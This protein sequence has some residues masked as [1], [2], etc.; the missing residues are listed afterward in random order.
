MS[1]T[2]SRFTIYNPITGKVVRH[3]GSAFMNEKT[4][5]VAYRI[6]ERGCGE[7]LMFDDTC[8]HGTAYA[9]CELEAS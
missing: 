4:S 6:A 8:P 1:I 7:T 2:Q 3:V 9:I 5:E